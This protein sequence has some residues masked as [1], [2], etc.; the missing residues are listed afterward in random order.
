MWTRLVIGVVLVLVGVV[1]FGQGVG[2]IG[3][4]FMT[5]E[6]FWAVMGVFAFA[7]GAVLLRGAARA[8]RGPTDIDD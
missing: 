7:V 8:R 1:W 6:A 4:S 3:G 5:G 2:A